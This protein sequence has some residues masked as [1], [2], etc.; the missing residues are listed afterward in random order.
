MTPVR[1]RAAADKLSRVKAIRRF[2][3]RTVLPE[4]I[5]PLGRLARN[6]R[7]SW[8]KP[9]EDLFAELSPHAWET[10]HGDPVKLLGSLTRE[11]IQQISQDPDL[12]ARIRALDADLE[13]YLSEPH[14]YQRTQG[15]D[16]PAA[17]SYT[18][19][20]LPTNREV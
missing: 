8:H 10:V 9:T 15:D 18:H 19:L 3:V 6:L 7:W 14:W 4:S 13:T 1:Q 5:A 12:V 16:A 20:T 11:E 2:T 17:V